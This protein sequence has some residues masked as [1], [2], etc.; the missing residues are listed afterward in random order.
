MRLKVACC[1]GVVLWLFFVG[2]AAGQEAVSPETLVPA[3][4]VTRSGT[5][6]GWDRSRVLLPRPVQGTLSEQPAVYRAS[7]VLVVTTIVDTGAGSLRQ[8]ILDADSLPGTDV[9]T[10]NIPGAGIHTVAPIL[11]LP[12]I[13]DPVLIDATTQP[14]FAGTPLIELSGVNLGGYDM[15]DVF[16]NQCV[17]KGL[18]IDRVPTGT[19]IVLYGDDNSIVG[20]FFGLDPS[21]TS[22]PG[23]AYNGVVCF[24]LNN[25]VGGT[26]DA[27]RNTF[28]GTGSPA[29]AVSGTPAVGTIIEGNRVGTDPTGTVKLGMQTE[30]VLLKAGPSNTVIGGVT[31]GS[32]NLIAGSTAASGISIVGPGTKSNLVIGNYI[33]TDRTALNPLGNSGNGIFIAGADSTLIGG[34]SLDSMN[35]I[36][37]NGSPGIFV[38]S[39]AHH[40]IIRGNNIG[41][42]ANA[43]SALPNSKGIVINGS[44]DNRI[45]GNA[46]GGNTLHGIEIRNPGAT[47]NIVRG[48]LIGV[49]PLAGVLV[50][51]NGHGLL[52]NASNTTVGGTGPGD[53]NTIAGNFGAGISVASGIKNRI[54]ANSIYSNDG[55]GIDLAPGGVNPND[56][57]DT[58]TGANEMQNFPELDSIKRS[59]QFTEIFGR[60]VTSPSRSYTVEF[61]AD[62]IGDP[63]GY[64]QGMRY[65][66]SAQ[67][68]TGASGVN[69]FDVSLP[70]AVSPSEVVTSTAT[71][72]SGNTSEFSRG[73]GHKIVVTQ[74]QH[75]ALWIVGEQ[76]TIMWKRHDTSQVEIDYSVDDGKTYKQIAQDVPGDRSEFFW[77]IPQEFS[78]KSRVR[79]RDLRDT[80][81]D[82][83]SDRFK[84][85]GWIL[86]K[87]SPDSSFIAYRP[88]FD[89]WNF[90]NDS[91][92]MW[93]QPWFSRFDY[94]DSL[95]PYTGAGYPLFWPYFLFA[96]P[97]DFPDWP[98]YVYT[99]G[100]A[101]CY[102]SQFSNPPIYKISTVLLWSLLS[103]GW[104]GSCHGLAITSLLAFDNPS[105]FQNFSGVG[106]FANLH[107]VGLTD[108]I[109]EI[110]NSVFLGQFSTIAKANEWHS[111]KDPPSMTLAKI[112]T[113]FASDIR[114][115][116]A[117]AFGYSSGVLSKWEGHSVVP[118]KIETDAIDPSIQYL[119]VY[120]N[121]YPGDTT[122]RFAVNIVSDTW[123]YPR[124]GWSGSNDM[125]LTD[126]SSGYL[127]QPVFFLKGRQVASSTALGPGSGRVEVYAPRS[128]KFLIINPSGEKIGWGDTGFVNSMAS[129]NLVRPM[130]RP[131][132][133]ALAY[134]LPRGSYS[135][136]GGDY[137][138]TICA[139]GIVTDSTIYEYERSGGTA[140]TADHL[141]VDAGVSVRNDNHTANRLRLT[142]LAYQSDQEVLCQISGI[143]TGPGD[144]VRLAFRADRSVDV[145]NAGASQSLTM[146]LANL[147]QNAM[148]AFE[149]SSIS[150]SG[151]SSVRIVPV[152]DNVQHAPVKILID[153]GM[154]GTFDDSVSLDNQLTSIPTEMGGSSTPKDFSLL[155]NYPNPFNPTTV[156]GVQWTEDSEVRLVVYD[157]LGRVVAV[158]ANG[159]YP[160]GKYSF[161][162][163][164]KG[165]ASGVYFYRLTAGDFVAT[166]AMMLLK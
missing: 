16:A 104:G 163:T 84:I 51:N 109:R 160:A 66:G 34:L 100:T 14:G 53:A 22:A 7:T 129:A 108:H 113:M 95:D 1:G 68:Q 137:A 33:G 155:Q 9:I 47:G 111:D 93:P 92:H 26:L 44:P 131:A 70:A 85:K 65:L 18:V 162:F 12:N 123:S 63:S 90:A 107:Q 149:H 146:R 114:D 52:L 19:G 36:C 158:L 132:R 151:A 73:I 76:D 141:W 140:T 116:R 88:D 11:K 67:F 126:P 24:G 75:G 3:V 118:Y 91:A 153:H 97:S 133:T 13:T 5:M 64:G 165:L 164:A 58:D 35:I 32:R 128:D 72:D 74:P 25:R 31:N 60:L 20:N 89:G 157:V 94:A 120:D 17:I 102:H 61:F 144:S 119:Y 125:Y 49:S 56:T 38:D 6:I 27:N 110:I 121:N 122:A 115:D 10:F 103:R 161:T 55:L 145:V 136:E 105:V 79:V 135:L 143:T 39:T 48:N 139:I 37:G 57:L 2:A 138:D 87:Y 8:A 117:I 71:D 166:K 50:G 83:V 81:I 46:I 98:L 147:T 41:I 101:A 80:T 29:I 78:A 142:G 156:I 150:I 69:T 154:H 99:F 96:K 43:L 130:V 86:T 54:S 134:D 59:P 4:S 77:K 23:I 112:K 15:L 21:G 45:E 152:W 159:R 28:A 82:G 62:S 30:G 106:P 127:S 124:Y 42:G 148:E 40:T